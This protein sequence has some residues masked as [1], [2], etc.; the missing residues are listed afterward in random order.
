MEGCSPQKRGTQNEQEGPTVV[1]IARLRSLE[2]F[3]PVGSVTLLQYAE[4][5]DLIEYFWSICCVPVS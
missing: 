3:H 2:D 1:G 5:Q 4:S